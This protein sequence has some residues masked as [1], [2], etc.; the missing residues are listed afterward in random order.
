MKSLYQDILEISEQV[1]RLLFSGDLENLPS[2]L[3]ERQKVFSKLDGDP[4]D[5]DG[6]VIKQILDCEERCKAFAIE[7]K[8]KLQKDILTTQNRKK[9]H[10]AYGKA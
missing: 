1:E 7:K 4:H 10:Q 9:L 2:L 5:V 3:T 6:V 8:E